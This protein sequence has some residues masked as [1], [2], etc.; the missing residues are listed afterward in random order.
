M[1]LVE[2]ISDDG[3]VGFKLNS[4]CVVAFYPAQVRT[5]PNSQTLNVFKTTIKFRGALLE[6]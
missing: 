3:G 2:K 5:Y 4:I 6:A 1:E